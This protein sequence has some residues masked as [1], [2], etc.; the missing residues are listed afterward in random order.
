M[1]LFLLTLLCISSTM[2]ANHH[3]HSYVGYHG[4]VVL[5]PDNSS[6]MAYHLPLYR[7]PHDYQILYHIELPKTL[8]K[9]IKDEEMITIL[10][11]KFDLKRLINAETLSLTTKIYRGHFE[12]GGELIGEYDVQFKSLI[13][14][15][16][17]RPTEASETF[18]YQHIPLKSGASIAVH[19]INSKPSFDAI[20]VLPKTKREQDIFKCPGFDAS[21]SSETIRQ[22]VKSCGAERLLYSEYLDFQ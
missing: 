18:Q 1:R 11:Q 13:W 2:H 21:I 16:K 4:M 10:P 22:H 7:A 3:Q 8:D 12:R 14:K 15:K 17:I 9:G 5:S 6:T 20:Y 19:I